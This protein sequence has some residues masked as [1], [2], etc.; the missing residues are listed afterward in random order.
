MVVSVV[1]YREA[2]QMGDV[3]RLHAGASAGHKSGRSSS[4]GI[5]VSRSIGSTNSA[6]TPRL[7]L[8]SQYETI[9]CLVPMRSAKG[10]CPP[11]TSQARRNAS[12]DMGA[13]YPILGEKQPKNQC[14]TGNL[15]FGIPSPMEMDDPVAFARRIVAR[16]SALGMSQADLRKALGVPQ[17]TLGN[18]ERGKVKRARMLLELSEALATTPQWLLR[19]E[20]PESVGAVTEHA[21]KEITE[22]IQEISEDNRKIL[23][24]VARK[25][26]G[27]A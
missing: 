23:L 26:R 8:V 1:D 19:G 10:F 6:G 7:D 24:R 4:R 13:P 25:L 12:L 15:L 20:G 11:A 17:Q 22:T 5:P 27:A 14:A 9:C 21:E 18:W 16:R 2:T 3:V